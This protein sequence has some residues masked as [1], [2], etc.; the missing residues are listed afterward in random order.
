MVGYWKKGHIEVSVQ[1]VVAL[2][3]PF[4]N[5]ILGADF[6]EAFFFSLSI[7]KKKGQI[8]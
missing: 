4:C 2:D 8:I 6:Y 5:I 7:F 1:G 3:G